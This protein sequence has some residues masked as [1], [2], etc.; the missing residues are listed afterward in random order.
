[1]PDPV[2]TA[3]LWADQVSTGGLLGL[4]EIERVESAN[5]ALS[6]HLELAMARVAATG[7][8]MCAGP[9]FGPLQASA[10]LSRRLDQVVE[11]PV[12]TAVAAK[13][14]AMSLAAWGDSAVGDGL[15]TR[16]ELGY[17]SGALSQL[18]SSSA[19]GEVTWLLRQ[20]SFVLC[21]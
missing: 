7:A 14:F 20:A 16:A 5:S 3:Q 12:A 2:A 19:K 15:C 11:V 21:A 17:L 9:L 8:T 1:M 6:A 18:S 10:G 4:D 13:M